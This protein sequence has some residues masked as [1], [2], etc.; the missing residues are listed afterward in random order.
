VKILVEW[1]FNGWAKNDE[2]LIFRDGVWGWV[3]GTYWGMSLREEQETWARRK[4]KT[5]GR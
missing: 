4:Q 2:R 1:T 5:K 3:S